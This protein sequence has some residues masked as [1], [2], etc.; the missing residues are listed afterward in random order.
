MTTLDRVATRTLFVHP[1]A[2]SAEHWPTHRL[3]SDLG[4]EVTSMTSLDEAIKSME[5]DPVD[6]LILEEPDKAEPALRESELRRIQS[7]PASQQPREIAIFSDRPGEV[8]PVRS[9]GTPRVHILIKPLH[10]H[11]LLH[12]IRHLHRRSGGATRS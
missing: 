2:D 9:T 7:L 6:L 1:D 12:V 5:G 11:G 10:M 3:L 4:H 8:A